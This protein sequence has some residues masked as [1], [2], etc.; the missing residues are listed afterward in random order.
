MKKSFVLLTI[1]AFSVLAFSQGASNNAANKVCAVGKGTLVFGPQEDVT[2]LSTEVKT[3]DKADLLIEFNAMSSISILDYN[4][5]ND[6]LVD[7]GSCRIRIDV[8]IEVDGNPVPFDPTVGD[9]GRATFHYIRAV[10]TMG[11]NSYSDYIVIFP[12]GLPLHSHDATADTTTEYW[13]FYLNGYSQA[14]SFKWFAYDVGHGTHIVE[15]KATISSDLRNV[16]VAEAWVGPRTL[17][18]EPLNNLR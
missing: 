16:N 2:L 10:K 1:L 9:N 6:N 14:N 3:S 12:S 17:V 18:V 7:S 5:I 15:V 4:E 11:I 8:W 13:E